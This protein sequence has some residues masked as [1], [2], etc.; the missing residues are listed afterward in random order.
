VDPARRLADHGDLAALGDEARVEI[1]DG[2]LV[3]MAS[4][5]FAHGRTQAAVARQ[6]G[7]PFDVDDGHGGPGGWWIAVEVEVRLGTH[8]IVR[9]D[10]SGWRRERLAMPVGDPPIDVAPDWICE[11]VSPSYEANDRV[12]KRRYYAEAGVP[13]YWIIDPLG[14]TLESFRLVSGTWVD[15]G[16]HGDDAVARIPPFEAVEIEVARLFPPP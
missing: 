4:P 11:I 14:R 10:L 2:T 6:V 8:R 9:P 7:G 1:L 13:F 15:A 3:P 16:S 5:S 12:H